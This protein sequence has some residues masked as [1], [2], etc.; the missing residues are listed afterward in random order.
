MLQKYFIFYNGVQLDQTQMKYLYVKLIFL[1]VLQNNK[2]VSGVY[3]LHYKKITV[4][5][6]RAESVIRFFFFVFSFL[7]LCI[8]R[9]FTAAAC[10]QQ[11]YNISTRIIYAEDARCH[12]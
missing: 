1:R 4:F 7:F 3:L 12:I 8:S 2:I 5:D 11:Y 10:T 6:Y 9:Y